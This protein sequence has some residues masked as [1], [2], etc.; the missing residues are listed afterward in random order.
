MKDCCASRSWAE[1]CA[2]PSGPEVIR[3]PVARTVTPNL[4]FVGCQLRTKK[5][6]SWSLAQTSSIQMARAPPHCSFCLGISI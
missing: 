1:G 4:P 5:I 2:G 6:S 3:T